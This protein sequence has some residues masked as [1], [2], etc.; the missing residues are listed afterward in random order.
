MNKL[1]W[2]IVFLTITA[3]AA[4]ERMQFVKRAI[5]VADRRHRFV[6]AIPAHRDPGALLPAILFLHG[7]GERGSWGRAPTRV[8]LGPRLRAHPIDAIVV[9]PQCERDRWWTDPAMAQLALAA[10]EAAIGEF[11]GD[12]ERQYL[13][14]LSMGGYGAIALALNEPGR[15]AALIA[16]CGGLFPPWAVPPSEASRAEQYRAAAERLAGAKLPVWLL[17]GAADRLIPVEASRALVAALRAAK[18]DVKYTE[19]PEV[20][21]NAWDLAYA[22][23]GLF[24]W[25]LAQ[26]RQ[27]GTAGAD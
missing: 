19:Y 9:F 15:W 21:H 8:G 2:L 27:A 11:H 5:E 3:A 14:G 20:G 10:F 23:P 17:H 26:R 24:P 1:L 4:E 12:R 22:E 16:I 25:L 7:A 13:T 6:V 18:S